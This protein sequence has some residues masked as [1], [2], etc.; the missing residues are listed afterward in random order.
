MSSELHAWALE[1][2]PLSRL[3]P[4]PHITALAPRQPTSLAGSRQGATAGGRPPGTC[5]AA[6]R[7]S[8]PSGERASRR[9]LAPLIC[10]FPSKT[11]AQEH[12]ARASRQAGGTQA[13]A[14]RT[15]FRLPRD[16]AHR[17]ER[18]KPPSHAAPSTLRPTRGAFARGRELW[19]SDNPRGIFYPTP[20]STPRILPH[21]RRFPPSQAARQQT[22][23]APPLARGL[24]APLG[25]GLPAAA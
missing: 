11:D 24:L 2:R 12:P 5:A 6:R 14:P 4:A 1:W 7:L 17:L 10:A 21:M 13:T 18:A 23:V 20:P 19:P 15:A 22:H 25:P 3:A 8:R 16:L 9:Q